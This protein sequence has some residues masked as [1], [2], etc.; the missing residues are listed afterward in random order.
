MIR[1]RNQMGDSEHNATGMSGA[2]GATAGAGA[3]EEEKKD[4]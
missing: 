3:G 4:G 1:E 2:A